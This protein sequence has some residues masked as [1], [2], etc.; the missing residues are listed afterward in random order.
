MRVPPALLRELRYLSS[1]LD[2]TGRRLRRIEAVLTNIDEAGKMAGTQSND[3]ISEEHETGTQDV[4]YAQ[5]I[6]Y[7]E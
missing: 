5:S 1:K 3:S 6:L 4:G 2:Q 7:L